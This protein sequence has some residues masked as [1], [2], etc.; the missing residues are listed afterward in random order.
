[1]Q[2]VIRTRTIHTPRKETRTTQSGQLLQ[3]ALLEELGERGVKLGISR[4][5]TRDVDAAVRRVRRGALLPTRLELLEDC[6]DVLAAVHR[7]LDTHGAIR[8]EG[9][10]EGV[11][12]DERGDEPAEELGRHGGVDG[13]VV[14]A[15]DWFAYGVGEGALGH[16][17]IRLLA[18]LNEEFG[19][20]IAVLLVGG[21]HD[22]G[23]EGAEHGVEPGRFIAARVRVADTRLLGALEG[24]SAVVALLARVDQ[25]RKGGGQTAELRE[26]LQKLNLARYA[27][28]CEQAGYDDMDDIMGLSMGKVNAMIADT[29]MR[30]RHGDR[31]RAYLEERRARAGL[32]LVEWGATRSVL[33]ELE[34]ALGARMITE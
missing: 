7:I 19:A 32:S 25:L 17:E 16:G 5:E 29:G 27:D 8:D 33:A 31:L 12:D 3:A 18:K 28:A 15:R 10:G 23:D 11:V 14:E 6:G 34:R 20:E 1:M 2:T 22:V 30:T 4:E 24:E 21:V 13:D 26:F 9:G